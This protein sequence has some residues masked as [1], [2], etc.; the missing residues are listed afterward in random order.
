MGGLFPPGP[1]RSAAPALHGIPK[2]VNAGLHQINVNVT[3]F[4]AHIRKCLFRFY[5]RV[6]LSN[7]SIIIAIAKS[8]VLFQS[9]FHNS[10]KAKYCTVMLVEVLLFYFAFFLC[11]V[12][13]IWAVSMRLG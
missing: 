5:R 4:D 11:F 3:T 1:P 8:D 6:E 10:F 9:K 13:C 12:L 2:Y 7:N